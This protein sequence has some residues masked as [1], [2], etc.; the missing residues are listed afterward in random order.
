MRDRL[1]ELLRRNESA[2]HSERED[3]D[4]DAEN[5]NE[6]G[7]EGTSNRSGA[8]SGPRQGHYRGDY[9]HF[10][11]KVSVSWVFNKLRYYTH[12]SV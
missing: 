6:Q 8:S 1:H 11:R 5:V 12:I 7:A 2:P 4:G 9:L 10:E 3:D